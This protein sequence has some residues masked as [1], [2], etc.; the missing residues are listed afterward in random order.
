MAKLRNR[1][2]QIDNEIK[3]IQDGLKDEH[4][5]VKA[6]IQSTKDLLK[7]SDKRITK[8]SNEVKAL[9]EYISN[10]LLG[11]NETFDGGSLVKNEDPAK[12]RN[13]VLNVYS[14]G[15]QQVQREEFERKTNSDGK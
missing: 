13:G 7:N 4:E 10:D 15:I 1:T 2:E 8:T 3:N 14:K 11:R 6:G 9:K 12:L 5:Q